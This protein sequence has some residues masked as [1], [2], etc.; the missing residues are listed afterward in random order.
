MQNVKYNKETEKFEAKAAYGRLSALFGV[1]LALDS[2]AT[3]PALNVSALGED[4]FVFRGRY[5]ASHGNFEFFFDGPLGYK[6]KVA[7][8]T[9][10]SNGEDQDNLK[11][12]V[13]GTTANNEDQKSEK[14]ILPRAMCMSSEVSED[15]CLWHFGSGES[16][17]HMMKLEIV[18]KDQNGSSLTDVLSAEDASIQ[19]PAIVQTKTSLLQELL[20]KK[21]PT[22]AA[23]VPPEEGEDPSVAVVSH[24]IPYETQKFSKSDQMDDV[25]TEIEN[26]VI[27]G[28][29]K[30][31]FQPIE[32]DGE[33]FVNPSQVGAD[34]TEPTKPKA[35][36]DV[37]M[38]PQSEFVKIIE[39]N[40]TVETSE[41]K[42]AKKEE[43]E[44][45][46]VQEESDPGDKSKNEVDEE[47]IVDPAPLNEEVEVQKPEEKP[48]KSSSPIEIKHQCDEENFRLYEVETKVVVDSM[49]TI[50]LKDECLSHDSEVDVN[51]LT[52]VKE[53]SETCVQDWD[54]STVPELKTTEKPGDVPKECYFVVERAFD[55]VT[56]AKKGKKITTAINKEILHVLSNKLKDFSNQKELSKEAFIK[57]ERSNIH[58]K[59]AFDDGTVERLNE[60]R[61]K[62]EYEDSRSIVKDV[63]QGDASAAMQKTK[64]EEEESIYEEIGE[65]D[66]GS[67]I[68]IKQK[69][70]SSSSVDDL[71]PP[72]S[73]L[74]PLKSVVNQ[75]NLKSADD[76]T[77][78]VPAGEKVT[79]VVKV[80]DV[81]DAAK[82][83]AE[84]GEPVTDV[85]ELRKDPKDVEQSFSSVN[86]LDD[87]NDIKEMY[88]IDVAEIT[89]EK[90]LS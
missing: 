1:P 2:D 76:S 83:T 46:P 13:S 61:E 17:M 41:E 30:V 12:K 65:S 16:K 53:V 58:T 69:Q 70:E 39:A 49:C 40:A 38:K 35:V 79:E 59:V 20:Q 11:V 28:M 88:H 44:E 75:V 74:P 14:L 81:E 71:P 8:S 26:P 5:T 87:P 57:V 6:Y 77:L 27:E 23:A 4:S 84:D 7:I 10:S 48:K 9:L 25:L 80:S 64:T 21:S 51:P 90:T 85:F 55:T 47:Q 66:E 15:R 32:E 42:V 22:V 33:I 56:V 89:V 82:A 36:D 45:V 19:N 78:E 63:G 86:T 67:E 54:D 50:A 37:S 24:V 34:S 62:L 29:P 18:V 72:P 52:S 43:E 31:N 73:P 68:A 3:L 60:R